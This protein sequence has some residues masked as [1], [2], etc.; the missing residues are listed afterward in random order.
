MEGLKAVRAARSQPFVRYCHPN[1]YADRV[2]V[3]EGTMTA[4]AFLEKWGC[5]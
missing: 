1:E 2:R 5:L 4:Q 3:A